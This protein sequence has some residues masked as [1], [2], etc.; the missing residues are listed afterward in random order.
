[1]LN[2]SAMGLALS[3]DDN[4]E[5]RTMPQEFFEQRGCSCL[6]SYVAT[7]KAMRFRES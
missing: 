4:I 5:A 2:N 6:L 1:M 3:A 7:I